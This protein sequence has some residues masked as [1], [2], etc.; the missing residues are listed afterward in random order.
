MNEMNVIETMETNRGREL[1][2]AAEVLLE[3]AGKFAVIHDE[4]EAALASEYRARVNQQ[5]KDLDAE[6]LDMGEGLRT[7][8]AKINEKFN[9]P[10]NALKAKLGAVDH[11]IKGYLQAQRALR[12]AAEKAAREQEEQRLIEAMAARREA[13]AAGLP[14]PDE[15]EPLPAPFI[16]DAP[17]SIE[18]S[19]G[20]KVS[21]REV[22]KYRIVDIKKVPEQ[23]LVPVEER[24]NKSALNA[25]ARSM[26]GEAKVKGIIFYAEE[27]LTSR[28]S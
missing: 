25:L 13:V 7:T 11:A 28:V 20:S 24:V 5:I 18:G 27:S 21:T 3:R 17:R 2:E 10:I 1:I 15:P 4:S 12:D 22:W 8:L 23:F 16:P 14:P 26:K 6:R 19:F 9:G